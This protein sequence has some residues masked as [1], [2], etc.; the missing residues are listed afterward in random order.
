MIFQT[1]LELVFGNMVR[2]DLVQ[3]ERRESEIF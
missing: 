1:G 2:P 3:S